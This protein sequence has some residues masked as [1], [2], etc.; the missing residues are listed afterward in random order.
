[1]RLLSDYSGVVFDGSQP[2]YGDEVIKT[3]ETDARHIV[4]ELNNSGC[5]PCRII[6]K[7]D[8]AS[9]SSIEKTLKG[10]ILIS[11]VQE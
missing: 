4:D 8:L 11:F 10:Q 3:V 1:V 5:F 2:L 9:P 7:P 6:W